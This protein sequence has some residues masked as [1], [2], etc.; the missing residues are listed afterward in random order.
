MRRFWRKGEP[1]VISN[2]ELVLFERTGE[3]WCYR[4]GNRD[5]V[6]RFVNI[7]DVDL[8]WHHKQHWAQRAADLNDVI[9]RTD[10]TA[11]EEARQALSNHYQDR[12]RP[13]SSREA[14]I[15]QVQQRR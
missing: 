6:D 5:G 13:E 4:P 1:P 3:R 10:G 8:A 11:Q 12:F 9:E 7:D 2:A 14:M 15:E